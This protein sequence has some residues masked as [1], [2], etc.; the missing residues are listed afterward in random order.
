[1]KLLTIALLLLSLTVIDG[2]ITPSVAQE[3]DKDIIE[4]TDTKIAERKNIVTPDELAGFALFKLNNQTPNYA[5]WVR[6][7]ERFQKTVFSQ[8][9]IIIEQESAR[10]KTLFDSYEVANTP[11]PIELPIRLR[12]SETPSNDYALSFKYKNTQNGDH[13]FITEKFSNEDLAILFTDPDI[14]GK[15]SFSNSEYEEKI[16]Q[17]WFANTNYSGILNLELIPVAA[18]T[19]NTMEINE[20][21]HWMM[22]ARIKSAKITFFDRLKNENVPVWVY[23]PQNN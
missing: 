2:N 23:N 12:L 11:I 1:M 21:P 8:R 10:L 16:K 18:N 3:N 17:Y 13:S 9:N 14:L 7:T 15:I 19:E 6:G 4:T 20:K 22:S 5:N